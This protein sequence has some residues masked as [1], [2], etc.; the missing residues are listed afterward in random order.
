MRDKPVF[1]KDNRHEVAGG[2]PGVSELK[3]RPGERNKKGLGPV[4]GG[5]CP[6]AGPTRVE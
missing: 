5:G 2:N 4:R 3:A 6:P 1:I